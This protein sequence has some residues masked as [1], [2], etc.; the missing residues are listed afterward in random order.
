MKQ[1]IFP[2]IHESW[3]SLLVDIGLSLVPN[4][5][6]VAGFNAGFGNVFTLLDAV[7]S[8]PTVFTVHCR[9][10]I[11]LDSCLPDKGKTNS[12]FQGCYCSR[13]ASQRK[14]WC[15]WF[16]TRSTDLED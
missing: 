11:C 4:V 7:N 1:C 14:C 3:S 2:K 16:K 6:A 5:L 13:S 9:P 8:M 10:E 15:G 12:C